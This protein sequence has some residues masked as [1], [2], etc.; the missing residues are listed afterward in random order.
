LLKEE[1]W[2]HGRAVKIT[3][4]PGEFRNQNNRVI[5]C[6]EATPANKAALEEFTLRVDALRVRIAALLEPAVILHTLANLGN[7]ALLP[8]PDT[9][10]RGDGAVDIA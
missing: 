1:S 5:A 2:H 10:T 7:N 3:A 6:I 9:A 8:P 4:W